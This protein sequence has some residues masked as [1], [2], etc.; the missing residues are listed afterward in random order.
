MRAGFE[1]VVVKEFGEQKAEN[2]NRLRDIC[3]H[4]LCEWMKRVPT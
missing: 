4:D 1:D 3:L 2:A